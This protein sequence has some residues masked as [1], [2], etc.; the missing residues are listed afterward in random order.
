MSLDRGKRSYFDQLAPRWDGMP[1]P[2]EIAD[3][4]AEFC[5]R[6]CPPRPGRVLDA[7]SG[8]GLLGPHVLRIQ[9]ARAILVELDFAPAMLAE[10][11]R[12]IADDRAVPVCAD[13]VALPFP[14]SAFDAVLCFGIL[15]HLG[16][17]WEAA[18][19]L[20]RVVAPAGVI[21]VG[22]LVGSRELNER[23]RS[24]GGPVAGD[25]LLPASQL[26][27]L[28]EEFGARVAAAQDTPH[29]Y[30]VVARRDQE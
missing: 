26:A 5:R 15:P 20:W 23:H 6:A 4:A 12:K 16:D 17:P 30:F 1:W 27:A 19:E 9:D 22:H 14:D 8:T 11:R 3:R 24:I 18:A 29:G 13:A 10:A 25:T 21:A 7:G 28:F 2:P